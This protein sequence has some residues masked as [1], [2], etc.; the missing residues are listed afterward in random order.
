MDETEG[1]QCLGHSN[2]TIC[3]P[4]SPFC[5]KKF[6]PFYPAS[7]NKPFLIT[8]ET[9]YFDSPLPKSDLVPAWEESDDAAQKKSFIPF[10]IH[11]PVRSRSDNLAIFI[12]FKRPCIMSQKGHQ[13][14]N[15]TIVQEGK[16]HSKYVVKDS[17]QQNR[18]RNLG[19]GWD[20]S[21]KICLRFSIATK[22]RI[23]I[24]HFHLI[25]P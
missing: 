23:A 5:P 12:L 21:A 16:T 14:H 15:S 17:L 10:I 20:G 24:L 25:D 13:Y 4:L 22:N 1:F 19:R 18:G 9:N 3:S 8:P 2:W 6:P 7:H 11:S